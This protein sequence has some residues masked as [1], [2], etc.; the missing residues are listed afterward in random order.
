M[1]LV[2]IDGIDPGPLRD[3]LGV[4]AYARGQEYV[5]QRR[6]LHTEWFEDGR[7]LSGLVR[8]SGG[9]VYEVEIDLVDGPR[10]RLLVTGGIC[11]CPLGGDCK[12]VAAVALAVA[13]GP[14]RRDAARPATQNW[15]GAFDALLDEGHRAAAAEERT[16]IALEIS[17]Q[18]RPAPP[19]RPG[20]APSVAVPRLAARLVRPGRGGWVAGGLSWSKLAH[21]WQVG[22][23]RP[24]H[25]RLLHELHALYTMRASAPRYA[26]YGEEK[27]I[28]LAEIDS[29]HL[30]SLLDEAADLG[31]RIVHAHKALGGVTLHGTARV[32]LDVTGGDP[33]V[34]APLLLLGPGQDELP[35]DPV[36]V[37][38]IGAVGHG[39]VWVSAS[40][41][42]T[43]E[44]RLW[45]LGLA[46]LAAPVPAALQQLALA[47]RRLT[48][49]AAGRA[50]FDAE[51][52]PRLRALATVE[53]SDG[54]WS[55]PPISAPT[56]AL[57]AAYGP[58][59]ALD[60]AW[61]WHYE[62]GG[63]T[64]RSP[65]GPTGDG[66]R[67]PV[68]ERAA[69]AALDAPLETVGLRVDG[70]LVPRAHMGG[71]QTMRFTTEVLPLLADASGVRVEYHGRPPAYRDAGDSLRI[72]VSADQVDGD[73]DW[74]DLGVEVRVDGR[75]VPFAELFQAL[76]LDEPHLLLADGTYFSLDKP[77]LRTL[78]QLIEEARALQ[79]TPSAGL[80]ISRFQAGLWEE[81]ATLGVVERQAAAW[82]EQVRGLLSTTALPDPDVPAGLRADLRPYQRE[83]LAWLQFLWQAR[84]GGILADDMGLGKTVQALALL[85]HARAADPDGPP[86]LVVAPTSVL[87]NWAAETA[88]FAPDLRVVTL[89]DTLRRRG[90]D[91]ATAVAGADVVLTTYALLRLDADAHAAHRWSGLLLD[92]AQHAKNHRSKVYQSA[93]RVQ[94]PFKLAITGTPMEN[95][96]MELW[97]LLSITAPGLF[98]HPTRFREH[99]AL[100]IEKGKD[101]ERLAALRRRI[102]PLVTRRS[103]EQVAVDLPAKQQQVLAVELDAKHRRTYQRHLQRERQK[104]LGLIDDVDRNRFTILRSLTLLRRL[105]LHP[106]LVDDGQAGAGSA[107]IDALIEHL[108]E[109]VSG[110]HRALVFSQF[111]GYLALVRDALHS[112]GIDP[113]YLDG[114][115]RNRGAVVQGFRDGAV[116]VFLIS[117]KAGGSGLNLAEADYVFLLDPWW[118]PA[119]EAQAIDR[120]HR[121][122]QTRIVHVYRLIA[123][124]TIEEKV[125]AL[126]ARKAELVAGVLDTGDPFDGRLGAEDIRALLA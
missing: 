87:P 5:R 42:A 1:Q 59:H 124:D 41:A 62:V 118:N 29:R 58:D 101:A 120:V 36:P 81:L 75:A 104:V 51:I 4:A 126:A 27:V 78:R 122:G 7:V 8:G 20:A 121:I 38:F 85:C 18:Q 98:P 46:R 39:V 95:D 65:L 106:G 33:L 24:A 74:F 23:Y 88:R 22:E 72:A 123:A 54:A 69:V 100:P 77:E 56:L 115:T 90:E 107:K 45:R 84:L 67:D 16:A 32:A 52:Y 61:E 40:Q 64:L 105:A 26:G 83:G 91:L 43:C 10:G 2:L 96:L 82:R 15:T 94:A 34:V 47:G 3:V 102:R 55:P 116:P 80:R 114:A 12:H 44:P 92:E 60:L 103:K 35:A 48:V 28:D 6:V 63:R 11:G 30:W 109:V 57:R 66:H 25:V 73:T 37:R 119:V 70:E 19:A 111:T 79:D 14:P 117:L 99:F 76:A 113:A 9:R 13:A 125:L 86:F 49:P 97:S 112:A 93:R 71:L 50:R 110:G 68:A 53:S 17:L 21:P 108:A 89:G 31:L